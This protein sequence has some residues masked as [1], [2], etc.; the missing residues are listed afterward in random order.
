MI[1]ADGADI[2]EVGEHRALKHKTFSKWDENVY[3]GLG[4]TCPGG[5]KVEG[6]LV[7]HHGD[8]PVPLDLEGST[9]ICITV[10]RA[11]GDSDARGGHQVHQIGGHPYVIRGYVRQGGK[12][13]E[14]QV[15]MV[16]VREDLFSRSRG[17]LETDVLK[18]KKVF[19]KGLGSVGSTVARLL[20][21]SGI[22]EF[23][24]MDND[25]LEV[26]NLVRHEA[27]LSHIGR[28]KTKVMADLIRE[29]NPYA[30][31]QTIEAKLNEGNRELGRECVR[32]A[33]LV[34]DTG[35]ERKG[36]L[37]L[38]RLCM[39]ENKRLVISGAF[40]RAHGG[41]VLRV[42]PGK[43]ACYQCF[44]QLLTSDGNPF[45]G[46][47]TEPIAYADRPVPIEPGLSIDIDPICHLT[48]KLGLQELLRDVP[49]TLR[50][51]DQDLE[52]NWYWF[53]NRREAGTQ[54]ES[55]EPLGFG[56]DGL[57]ILRWYGIDFPRNP[58]CV[59][60]G[61]L[62]AAAAKEGD[63]PPTADDFAA[64]LEKYAPKKAS[65]D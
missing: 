11:E 36:K 53:L 29:K 50:S 19:L 18:G 37:L 15:R 16:P 9:V 42:R 62:A 52:A 48:A 13:E 43:S 20:A 54:Y 44:C 46:Q 40:R 59:V 10:A 7:C 5:S 38:N 24:L 1:I 35:D 47:E 63:Q 25:R 17:L 39:E 30:M 6:T 14:D 45:A 49:T 4:A 41:Q 26:S 2:V 51:L 65:H 34:I 58:E 55:L 64:F 56:M 32:R 31:V 8:G 28:L 57:R 12:W 61:D 21:Q 22:G 33:D 27:G 23:L 60:C 3:N